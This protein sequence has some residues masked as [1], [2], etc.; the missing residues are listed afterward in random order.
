MLRLIIIR[1][2]IVI[3]GLLCRIVHLLVHIHVLLGHM[4]LLRPMDSP[5]PPSPTQSH[6]TAHHLCSVTC[7]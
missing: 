2:S 5:P 6:P 4:H 1:L 3:S 7:N